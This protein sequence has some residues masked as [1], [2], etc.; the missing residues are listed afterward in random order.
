MKINKITTIAFAVFLAITIILI[1]FP[2]YQIN[3]LTASISTNPDIPAYKFTEQIDI[4][5]LYQATAFQ[6]ASYV[7]AIVTII[8]AIVFVAQ[9]VQLNYRINVRPVENKDIK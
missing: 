2:I 5:K 3:N 4:W 7:L 6:P 8:I 9:L 1:E